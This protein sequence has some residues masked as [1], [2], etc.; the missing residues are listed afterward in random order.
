MVDLNWCKNQKAGIKLVSPN[1]NLAKEYLKNAEET[2]VILKDID[3]KSNMWLSTMKYYFEYFCAY[4]ILMKIGIKCEIHDCTISLCDILEEKE[5]ISKTFC[6]ALKNDKSLRIENQYYLKNKKV[7]M[8]YD[9]LSRFLLETKDVVANLNDSKI[10]QI[11]GN[12]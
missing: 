8:N 10:K 12:I 2:F 5:I 7:D 6:D 3:G 9:L 4:A 11:R 1:S